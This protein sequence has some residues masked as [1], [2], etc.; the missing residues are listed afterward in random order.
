MTM[1]AEW[2]LAL[3]RGEAPEYTEGYE[4]FY[5]T[6]RVIGSTAKVELNMLLRDHDRTILEQRKQFLRSLTD[7]MNHKYGA[8]SVT[9]D[10]QDMYCNMKDYIKPAY[11]IVEKAMDAMRAQGVEPHII[12]IR[13]GTDGAHLSEAGLPCPNLFTGGYN[14]HGCFEFLPFS[15]LEKITRVL[16]ELATAAAV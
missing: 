6:M 2:Q 15:S 4:G 1:A 14:F 16:V 9:C 8:G 5:H 12:P 10:L 7:F 3:P 11:E 13:G